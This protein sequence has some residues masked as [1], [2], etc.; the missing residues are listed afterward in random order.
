MKAFHWMLRIAVVLLAAGACGWGAPAVPRDLAPPVTEGQWVRP[1][2]GDASQPVWGIKGGIRVGLWPTPGPRGLIRIYAPY[3]GHPP[4]RMINFIA[5]EPVV[6]RA[7]GLSELEPSALDGVRG[8][9]MWTGDAM[10]R[11]PR[12]RK[13]WE[14]ARGTIVQVDGVGALTFFVFV[15]PFRNGARPTV[16]VTLREHRPH[17]VEFRVFAAKGS[18]AMKNCVLTATMGNYARLRHLWLKSEVVESTKLWPKPQLNR[19][20]FTAHREWG[21][22]RMYVSGGLAKVAATPN[23]RSPADAAYAENVPP[24]WRYRGETAPQYWLAPAHKGLVVRVNGRTTYWASQAP[25]PGGIAYENFELVAPFADGQS[26]TFGVLAG[27]AEAL[28]F[29]WGCR[30]NV[31]D[32]R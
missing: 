28:G 29:D 15:E 25:I 31:T 12:P 11:E 19:H 9:A 27:L 32:G 21:L 4:L 14:P 1:A 7:R 8:K 17:E 2:V 13:P 3:L 26:F 5:I 6:G 10:D 20:G 23:E 22:D 18:A 16:Q 30:R 24:F